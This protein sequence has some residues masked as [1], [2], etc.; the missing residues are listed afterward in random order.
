M[1]KIDTNQVL[2]MHSMLINKIGGRDGVRD[3][4]ILES[5]LQAPFHTF[6]G[7]DF[8]PTIEQKAARLCY[9]LI[10]NHSFYDGNKRIGVL[11]FLTFL[12]I[13]NVQVKYTDNELISIGISI[14]SDKMSYEDLVNNI[15]EHKLEQENCI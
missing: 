10:K 7:E 14:A 12:E 6:F 8:Y 2:K 4:N 11:V 3:F 1:N 13:N 9:G 15:Y 5:A